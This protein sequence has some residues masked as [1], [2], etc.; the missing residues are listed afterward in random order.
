MRI[1]INKILIGLIIVLLVALLIVI[2]R[3]TEPTYYAV[4]LRTGE[5]YF[6]KLQ[7]FP[8]LCLIDPYLLRTNVQNPEYP[9]SIQDFKQVFWGPENKLN[10]NSSQIVISIAAGITTS[11]ISRILGNSIPILRIMPNSAILAG[12]GMCVIST[13][14]REVDEGKISFVKKIFKSVGDIVELPEESLDAVTGLSGSGPAYVY[15]MIQGLIKGGKMAGLTEDVSRRL[16]TQTVLG[17]AKLLKESKREINDLISSI[18]TPGGTT[19]EGLKVLR[20]G[21]FVDL[22]ARA[23]MKATQRARQIRKEI[24]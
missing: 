16:A 20:E 17:A 23:V 8:R 1:N 15:L 19:V 2:S 14:D 18:A 3:K 24:N 22:I 12:E 5:L 6:G 9:F 4:Y 10:L 21:N 11:F 13:P 7:R